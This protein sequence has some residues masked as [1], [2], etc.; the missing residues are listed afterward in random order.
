MDTGTSLITVPTYEFTILSLMWQ[1]E[2]KGVMCSSE[3]CYS[4]GS[5]EIAAA[6]IKPLMFQFGGS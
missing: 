5:C 3:I 1:Q 2:Y 6:K 4:S